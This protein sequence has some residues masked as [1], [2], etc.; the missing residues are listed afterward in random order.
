MDD[1]S[2]FHSLH[3]VN[4]SSSIPRV[5]FFSFFLLVDDTSILGLFIELMD[6]LKLF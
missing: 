5:K 3:C 1:T 2:I 4:M 6:L